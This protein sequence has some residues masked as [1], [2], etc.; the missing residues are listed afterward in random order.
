[1]DANLKETRGP[2]PFRRDV[3][4]YGARMHVVSIS[5]DS[6]GGRCDT[7]ISLIYE[8]SAWPYMFY[9]S[10]IYDQGLGMMERNREATWYCGL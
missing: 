7:M 6:E 5:P 3:Y 2:R 10:N 9:P 8:G 4:T 1:M